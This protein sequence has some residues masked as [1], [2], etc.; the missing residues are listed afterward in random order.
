MLELI[1]PM[2]KTKEYFSDDNHMN[3]KTINFESFFLSDKIF[4]EFFG[5]VHTK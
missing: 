4:I 1:P 5:G 2:L 3:K